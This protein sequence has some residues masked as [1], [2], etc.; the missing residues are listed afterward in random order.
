MS[1]MAARLIKFAAPNMWVTNVK[2]QYSAINRNLVETFCIVLKERKIFWS[3]N[4][5]GLGKFLQPIFSEIVQSR[6]SQN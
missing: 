6:L 2:K 3:Q 5:T 4:K 1:I